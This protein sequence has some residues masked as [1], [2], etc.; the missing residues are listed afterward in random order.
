MGSEWTVCLHPL[1]ERPNE[2]GQNGRCTFFKIYPP[3]G[4]V[5][6]PPVRGPPAWLGHTR[7]R[8]SLGW[9]SR[10]PCMGPPRERS[11]RRAPACW[12][13]GEFAAKFPI[14]PD[15]GVPAQIWAKIMHTYRMALGT[16]EDWRADI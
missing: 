6:A 4:M 10:T 12:R 8:H 2:R 1:H 15:F 9:H 7:W 16:V 13:Q 3:R 11:A 14:R 5:G